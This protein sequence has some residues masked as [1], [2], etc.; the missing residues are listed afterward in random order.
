[1]VRFR[2]ILRMLVWV[3]AFSAS[4][5]LRGQP[6]APGDSIAWS[7]DLADVVVTAQYAPTESRNALHDVRT[8][9]RELIVRRGANNLEQLLNQEVN[10]RISQDLVLGSRLSLLGI[11]GQNVKI[12][13]DGV[14]V[15]GR[16]DGNID[17]SQLNLQNIE[18]VEIVEGPLSVSYGTDALAG[19]I[20]LITKKSQVA[21]VE[22]GAVGQWE[23]RG[24]NSLTAFVGVRPVESLLIRLS[25]GWDRF[26]GFSV[27]TLRSVLW[28]PKEQYYGEASLRY[29]LGDQASLRYAFNLFD[30]EVTNL[31]NI[32]RPQF[33]PYAF[34]DFFH[35]RRQDHSLNFEGPVLSNHYLKITSGYNQFDRI[36]NTFRLDL[37]SE[38]QAEVDG[39]QDTSQFNTWM[40]RGAFASTR[41]DARFHYQLGFDLRYDNATGRRINDTLSRR[42]GFSEI[43]DY[44]LF[45]SLRYRPWQKLTLET[46]LRYA[47][48]TRYKAPLVPS[49][50][51]KYEFDDQ[52]TLRASYGKGFR[53]PDLKELFFEF[54]DINHF[55]VGN[56]GLEAETSDNWQLGLNFSRPRWQT[57]VKGF[58]NH[59]RNKIELFEFLETP[60]GIQP[61]TD[62]STLRFAYFNQATFKTQGITSQVRYQL[63]G[64][65]VSGGFSLIGYYNPLSEAYASVDEFTY[66]REWNAEASYDFTRLGANI[67]VFVRGNDRLISFF[68]EVTDDGET[69]A[70]QRQQ[71]GFTQI[72]LTGSKHFWGERLRLT[73]GV[74]NLLDVTQVNV[75]GVGGSAHNGGTGLAPISPGRNLF[76]RLSVQFGRQN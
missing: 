27:D 37:E 14:P 34:D 54:I 71:E 52:L 67:S 62:T 3:L 20:N 45:A 63:R 61:V 76:V 1:M 12:M 10:I 2:H 42:E 36:K 44:A 50:N 19:V 23:D 46:G 69:I 56:P 25:G 38:E 51:A 21:P 66:T 13:I 57:K 74:K 72:D 26:D 15:I 53:S 40:A 22:A 59:I 28:N 43:G 5:G 8:L 16:Q 55:I 6:E 60:G 32:R 24:E 11:D 65:S 35:T 30:E 73:A 58:Y 31:G 41:R 33:K 29:R 68:P 4:H 64:L 9:D 48:N 49:F 70:G 17:L 75:S 47:Y 7:V 39:Q 18:R